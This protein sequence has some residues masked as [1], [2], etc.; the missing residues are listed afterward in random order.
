MSTLEINCDAVVSRTGTIIKRPIPILRMY[1]N[2]S[3]TTTSSV[4]SL[5]TFNTVDTN[6]ST[7]ID[8]GFVYSNGK[9]IN[10]NTSGELIVHVSYSL[11][12]TSGSSTT[13][14]ISWIQVG[15]NSSRH[16]QVGAPR[17]TQE[18]TFS[19]SS[20]CRVPSSSYI[21]LWV[22]QT[23]GLPIQVVA[24]G[25]NSPWLQITVI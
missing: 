20:I 10:T 1:S 12:F 6:E 16:A 7:S 17:T 9:F 11:T 3:V 21:R 22:W 19:G 2:T 13:F 23:T 14:C 24:T 15:E 25:Y 5:I 18:P 8:T 4:A